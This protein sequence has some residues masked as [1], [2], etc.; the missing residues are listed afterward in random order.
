MVA[1]FKAFERNG[2]C[3]SIKQLGMISTGLVITHD[4]H[5]FLFEQGNK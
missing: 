4:K 3:Y 2:Y 5:G 1:H